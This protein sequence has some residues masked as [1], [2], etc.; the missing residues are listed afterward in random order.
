M[1]T[2]TFAM[3]TRFLSNVDIGTGGA[4]RRFGG[5]R[6]E[7]YLTTSLV[8]MTGTNLIVFGVDERSVQCLKKSRRHYQ[9]QHLEDAGNR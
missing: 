4:A 2:K 6:L 7:E 3:N 9:C 1:R 5:N 8:E